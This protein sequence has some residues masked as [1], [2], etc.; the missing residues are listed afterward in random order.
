MPATPGPPIRRRQLGRRLQQLREA[1]GIT[2]EQVM[3]ALR[4]TRPR[5]TH[6]EQGRNP[7]KYLELE[8]LL[9]LFGLTDQAERAELE[10][11]RDQGSRRGWTSSYRLPKHLRDYIDLETDAE[12]VRSFGLEVIPGLLQTEAYARS[13]HESVPGLDGKQLE[14]WVKARLRRQLRLQEPPAL[15]LEVVLSESSLRRAAADAEIGAAQ[16][17]YLTQQAERPNVTIRILSFET[18]LRGL[19]S[20]PFALLDFNPQVSAPFAYTEASAGGYLS[21]DHEVLDRLN[22]VFNSLRDVALS[23]DASLRFINEVRGGRR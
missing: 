8:R 6:I 18:G 14:R 1:A 22:F 10:E 13:T 5:I 7:P 19:M 21:D 3:T 15:K 16:L 20:T 2:P 9:D 17:D 23:P 11:M 4:C 12:S